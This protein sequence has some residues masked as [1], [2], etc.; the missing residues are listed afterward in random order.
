MMDSTRISIEVND[1]SGSQYSVSK[2]IRFKT[3]MRRLDLYDSND[4]CI[5]VKR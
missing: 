2:N 5:V 4:A 1:L 3:H